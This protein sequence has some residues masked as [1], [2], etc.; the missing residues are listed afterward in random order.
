MKVSKEVKKQQLAEAQYQYQAMLETKANVQNRIDYYDGLVAEGL[1]GWETVQQISTHTATAFKMAEGVAHMLAVYFYLVPNTGSP[2][3]M[4]YGGKELGTSAAEF[5]QWTSSL[6]AV[7]NQVAASAGLEASWNRREQE[8]NQQLTLAQQEIKQVEQ[9]CLAAEI[10]QQ[11]AE[12]DLEIHKQQIE[13]A[14]ELDDFYKN[15]FTNLGLYTY[16]STK[17]NRLYREAYNI[18]YDMA[19]MAEKAYQF[20]RDDSTIFVAGDNWQYDRAGLL[21]G[22]RL[23]LQLQHMEKAY[24]EKNTRSLEMTQSF[25]LALLNPNALIDLRNTGEC[26]EFWIPEIAYDLVYPGQYKRIIKSVRLSIPCVAGPHT[27]IGATLTLQDNKVRKED[28]KNIEVSE[29]SLHG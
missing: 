26:E 15:K 21:A 22:E 6:A 29:S 2:F 7:A 14:D 25:S 11:I 4:T 18:A 10:R 9:Q 28:Q 20:E 16:L 23:L 3:A 8:W 1:S 27:N 24:L 12:K 19:K 17:L 5:A 13:H